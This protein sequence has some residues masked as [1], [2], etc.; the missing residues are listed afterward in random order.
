MTTTTETATEPA[1]ENVTQQLLR[2]AAQLDPAA[3]ST[4]HL[5]RLQ[6]RRNLSYVHAVEERRKQDLRRSPSG[7]TRNW[8]S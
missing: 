7:T 4:P 5:S 1:Q 3:W 2:R 6:R 8:S